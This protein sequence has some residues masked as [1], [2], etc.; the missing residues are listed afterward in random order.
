M[1]SSWNRGDI[2]AAAEKD[3]G[4]QNSW[5]ESFVLSFPVCFSVEREK[6]GD[7][8]CVPEEQWQQSQMLLMLDRNRLRLRLPL[9]S[10]D[11]KHQQL[12]KWAP[13]SLA[14]HG[15]DSFGQAWSWVD[16]GRANK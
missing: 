9:S 7:D 8:L 1:I 12:E 16:K 15:E 3:T 6:M 5:Q 13:G 10:N 11:R 14:G 4:Q 2:V